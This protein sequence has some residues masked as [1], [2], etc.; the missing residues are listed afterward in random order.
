MATSSAKPAVLYLFL[1]I[2]LATKLLAHL[3]NLLVIPHPPYEEKFKKY[4]KCAAGRGL[5]CMRL[6]EA[7]LVARNLIFHGYAKIK[8]LTY[9]VLSTPFFAI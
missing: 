2:Q 8:N 6:L 7:L 3:S 9:K 1:C 5:F 4:D